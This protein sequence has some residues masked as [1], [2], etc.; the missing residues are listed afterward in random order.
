[1]ADRAPNCRARRRRRGDRAAR[2]SG[3]HA[4]LRRARCS[5]QGHQ[6][7]LRIPRASSRRPTA[8]APRRPRACRPRA[9]SSSPC[10]VWASGKVTAAGEGRAGRRCRRPAAAASRSRRGPAAPGRARRRRTTARGC[11]ARPARRAAARR[12]PAPRPRRAGP[13]G[14][15]RSRAAAA[16]GRGARRASRAARSRRCRR[17]TAPRRVG[18]VGVE[19]V[20]ATSTGTSKPRPSSAHGSPPPRAR[21]A[22]RSAVRDGLAA[23]HRVPGAQPDDVALGE[24]APGEVVGE[25]GEPPGAGRRVGSRRRGR[26]PT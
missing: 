1:M 14:S 20:I 18:P 9:S 17:R 3:A 6:A 24:V 13:A 2:R 10:T 23:H 11:R 15:G 8:A 12:G 26:R 25:P 22:Y 19:Y 21:P 5:C 16:E 7:G 4:L